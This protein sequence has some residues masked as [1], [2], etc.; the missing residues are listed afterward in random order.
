MRRKLLVALGASALT[1]PLASFAQQQGK[2]W[3]IGFLSENEQIDYVQ[4]F[5]AFTAGMRMLG[6]AEGKNYVME[7]RSAQT[8]LARLPALVAELIAL[9]VDLIVTSGTRSAVAAHNATLEIPILVPNTADPVGAGLAATLKHP[10]GNVTGLAGLN[11]ELHTKRIDLLRQIL[12]GMRRVGFLYN[13]DGAASALVFKQFEAACNKL[14]F[15]PI[16][17]PLRKAQEIAA[18]FNTLKRDKAQGLIVSPVSTNTGW[19]ASIIEHAA[20]YR[21]PAVYGE[22][23]FPESG[24]LISYA[25]NTV[26][27]YR[28]AA[29]YADKIFKGA[30]PGDLPIE[31]PLKFETVINLKTAKALGIKFPDGIMLR[32]DKVI[33]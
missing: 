11:A 25:A 15:K 7:H 29:A 17:A 23:L 5:D 24:G 30:K 27:Q 9:K 16:R 22:S 13:P 10:G 20:K 8:D 32:A 21:L 12:P 18:A 14:Q 31:Q 4:R 2:V 26:D 3:R 28:R 1:A 6:Y 19:R 33:E